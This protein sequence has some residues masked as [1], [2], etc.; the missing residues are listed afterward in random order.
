MRFPRLRLE[1]ERYDMERFKH[2]NQCPSAFVGMVGVE[3]TYYNKN[4]T[5]DDMGID[6]SRYCCC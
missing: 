4:T 1:E 3:V 2:L 5:D 6:L